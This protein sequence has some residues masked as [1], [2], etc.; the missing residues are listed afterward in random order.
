[1]AEAVFNKLNRPENCHHYLIYGMDNA[2]TQI[3]KEEEHL[4]KVLETSVEGF[5]QVDA[6]GIIVRTNQ[7][8]ANMIGVSMEQII[9]ADIRCV[10]DQENL[11]IMEEQ[12]A[13]RRQGVSSSYEINATRPCDGKSMVCELNATPLFDDAGNFQGSFA[14]ISDITARKSSE[15][16]LERHRLHLEELI[17]ERTTE[18]TEK[19][20]MLQMEIRSRVKT[21]GALR[22]SDE[23]AKILLNS[24]QTGIVL[25]DCESKKIIE[26]N[27]IAVSMAGFPR[28]SLLGRNCSELFRCCSVDQPPASECS[29]STHECS[30]VNSRGEV[31]P[32]LKS[33]VMVTVRRRRCQLQSFLDLTEQKEVETRLREAK[34]AA[35][36][37]T[38]AKSVFLANMSHEIRTPLNAIIGMSELLADTKLDEVQRENAEIIHESGTHLLSIINDILDFSKIEAGKLEFDNIPF[39]L[40]EC[41]D[42]VGDILGSKA[43]AKGL[44]FVIMV[45]PDLPDLVKGDPIRLRQVL[46]NLCNNAIKFTE[47]GLVS[48]RVV[49]SEAGDNMYSLRFSVS[50]TGIGIPRDRMDRLFQS[51]SQVDT[52]TTRK[53]GGT[54]LGLAICKQL[55]EMMGGSI[56]VNSEPGKGSVF[57]FSAN[58]AKVKE[59]A[60]E[61]GNDDGQLSGCKVLV[62]DDV[63]AN[64]QLL[65]S[66]LEARGCEVAEVPGGLDA[67]ELLHLKAD[68]QEFFDVILID[69]LMPILDGLGLARYIK[70]NP[71]LAPTPLVLLTSVPDLDTSH[72]KEQGFC[73]FLCKPLK[74][75]VLYHTLAAIMSGDEASLHLNH[76]KSNMPGRLLPKGKSEL[77]RILVAEDNPVNQKVTG[78]ILAKLGFERFDLAS[79]GVEAIQMARRHAYDLIFMD[80]QMPELDGYQATREIRQHEC[81]VNHHA[82]I[83]AMTAYA[84][85]GDREKCLA[86]GMDD[87]ITK[88][89]DINKLHKTLARH[90]GKHFEPS[91]REAHPAREADKPADSAP[92]AAPVLQH[93]TLEAVAGDDPLLRQEIASLFVDSCGEIIAALNDAIA[94]EDYPQIHKHAHS[95]KGACGNVGACRMYNTSIKLM[96]AADSGI[97]EQC[98]A[99]TGQLSGDF[100]EVRREM[101]AI[102]FGTSCEC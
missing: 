96:R 36:Q 15:L 71:V 78:S 74:T 20:Q 66:L 11:Q 98:K 75:S 3:R 49:N 17:R 84:L 19:N 14:F 85:K 52:S 44:E 93:K 101:M 7:A 51:F 6:K 50:D 81:H 13:M 72:L 97:I 35:E 88:P 34:A 27:D 1:M 82:T 30:M 94:G 16:E 39:D 56:N 63:D 77:I 69:Y 73:H 10:C 23:R 60:H 90:L 80:C 68:R 5:I 79:N 47:K 87:Y 70:A 61:N 26:I 38:H 48:L 8:M 37:A 62:V 22:E 45:D 41:I 25:I 58:F 83:V 100:E 67:L 46:V 91:L 9:G 57:S 32:I 12:M 40:R 65:R 64:R 28:E 31:I 86:A 54:G 89:V 95:L 29:N 55:V 42:E 18:L 92:A 99:M 102:T 53:F 33:S 4:R 59:D 76:K 21:E 43:H 24:V 2:K